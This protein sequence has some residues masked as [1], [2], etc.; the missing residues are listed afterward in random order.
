MAEKK[1]FSQ[2]RYL[3]Y[4]KC[5]KRYQLTRLHKLPEHQAWYLVGGS[6]VHRA[7]ET[8]DLAENFPPKN[9]TVVETW[10]QSLAIE[11]DE[12]FAEDPD[13][14]NWRTGK[15]Y[16]GRG[17]P[18]GYDEWVLKGLECVKDWVDWRVKQIRLGW[19]LVGIEE[20]FDTELPSG[21]RIRGF[22]DRRFATP[23]GDFIV[24]LKTGSRLPDSPFQLGVYATGL[25]LEGKARPKLGAYYMAKTGTI[26]WP[27][28]LERYSI[29][30][31]DSMA[32][33]MYAG[34]DNR[35]YL[36]VVSSQCYQCFAQKA[37]YV[38]S[39]STEESRFYDPLDPGY[40]ER[41]DVRSGQTE[42]QHLH[43]DQGA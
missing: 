41:S 13:M 4:A 38:F 36:P 12:A 35:V 25:E 43:Q 27:E 30:V 34:I 32:T 5:G 2:S 18:E 21:I 16:T 10:M 17:Q 26:T 42:P 14:D 19:D 31:V 15:G 20:P 7:T 37:C 28:D 11:I 40:V 33:M 29:A 1:S 24:D 39:G 23:E 22:V 6:A 3:D 9:A 8:L